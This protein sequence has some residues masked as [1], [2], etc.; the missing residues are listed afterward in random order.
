MLR[1]VPNP[2]T[3]IGIK[4]L[5][6]A[7]ENTANQNTGK[8]LYTRQYYVQPSHHALRVCRIDCVGHYFLWH[9]KKHNASYL[10]FIYKGSCVFR[11]I[12]VT[13]GIF[14]GMPLNSERCMTASFT[15]DNM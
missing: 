9:G 7:I 8:T 14:H 13:R 12:Q 6:H 15:E 11:E 3:I 1:P 10:L 4:Y 2:R 5:Y